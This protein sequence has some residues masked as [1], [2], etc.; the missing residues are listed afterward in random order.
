VGASGRE[1]EVTVVVLDW[2]VDPAESGDAVR[3]DRESEPD[4]DA[5]E[6]GDGSE[7]R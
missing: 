1:D 7:P 4:G 5:K 6:D 2:D 3:I